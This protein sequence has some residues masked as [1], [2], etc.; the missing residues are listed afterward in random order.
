MAQPLVNPLRTNQQI[1]GAIHLAMSR[2][3]LAVADSHMGNIRRE[4][5]PLSYCKCLFVVAFGSSRITVHLC[6]A[7]H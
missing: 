1:M 5:I 4:S 2:K 7:S 6:H 3:E